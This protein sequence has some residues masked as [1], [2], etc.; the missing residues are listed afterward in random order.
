[1]LS[2][3]RASVP[4]TASPSDNREVV[5]MTA[6]TASLEDSMRAQQQQ[7]Q[8]DRDRAAAGEPTC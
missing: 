6:P 4:A 2:D 7:Q 5:V 1:M 3:R 8:Q